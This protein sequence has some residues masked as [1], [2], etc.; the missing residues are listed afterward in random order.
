MSTNAGADGGPYGTGVR[1]RLIEISP[2]RSL[3]IVVDAG[4]FTYALHHLE[5][6]TAHTALRR[7]R[8][9]LKSTGGW[10]SFTTPSRRGR[11][12]D[13]ATID[14]VTND[15]EV[16]RRNASRIFGAIGCMPVAPLGDPQPLLDTIGVAVFNDLVFVHGG[17]LGIVVLARDG[18]NR[19]YR[20]LA[21][22]RR[23]S[24]PLGEV[25]EYTLG[26]RRA[27]V[28]VQNTE[29]RD[30]EAWY[31]T[32]LQ[33]IVFDDAGN[34]VLGDGKKMLRADGVRAEGGTLVLERNTM[35]FDGPPFPGKSV[36]FCPHGKDAQYSLLDPV[37]REPAVFESQMRLEYLGGQ[38]QPVE[39]SLR[40]LQPGVEPSQAGGIMCQTF[41]TLEAIRKWDCFGLGRWNEDHTKWICGGTAEG[42]IK[43]SWE[44]SGY[45][46][47]GLYGLLQEAYS[48]PLEVDSGLRQKLDLFWQSCGACP[49]DMPPPWGLGD[50]EAFSFLKLVHVPEP[51]KKE[52]ADQ[53]SGARPGS[54]PTASDGA[55]PKGHKP[56]GGPAGPAPRP[57]QEASDSATLQPL[58]NSEFLTAGGKP[59]TGVQVML[60]PLLLRLRVTAEDRG[61]SRAYDIVMMQRG[62][63]V[64]RHTVTAV[65][66]DGRRAPEGEAVYEAVFYMTVPD[67]P[68][69]ESCDPSI[70]KLMSPGGLVDIVAAEPGPDD[71]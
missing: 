36:I 42:Y 46:W 27:Y 23:K 17:D 13:N 48:V 60:E 21:Q 5:S 70:P 40:L 52:V 8:E 37:S 57:G 22:T 26:D 41:P 11:T 64:S 1:L 34:V 28:F 50:D 31:P 30:L 10:S 61:P 63:E 45:Y 58:P 24:L 66:Q 9:R 14:F 29:W 55:A 33:V 18:G 54:G 19:K 53:D 71:S 65:R 49:Y 69:N 56:T 7:E 2:D 15:P 32:R 3:P 62:K 4:R 39:V 25:Q 16:F 47:S 12:F 59:A 68:G 44:F 20:Y 43:R 38:F 6:T 51:M 35:A 67:L